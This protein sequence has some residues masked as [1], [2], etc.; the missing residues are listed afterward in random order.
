MVSTP[1]KL[2]LIAVLILLAVGSYAAYTKYT[3]SQLLKFG[4]GQTTAWIFGSGPY[5]GIAPIEMTPTSNN[6]QQ[7]HMTQEEIARYPTTKAYIDYMNTDAKTPHNS[8]SI[9]LSEARSLL[10]FI[11]QKAN[12]ELKP[13]TGSPMG[14]WYY[15]R[16]DVSGT[17]YGINILFSDERPVLD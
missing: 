10:S 5:T 3:E 16:I 7:I 1:T 8:R 12:Y 17:G 9:Y 11:S 14:E 15:F 13:Q 6:D 4:T 2:A